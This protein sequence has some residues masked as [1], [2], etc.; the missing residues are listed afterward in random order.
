MRLKRLE[1]YG[2]KSF[3]ERTRMEFGEGITGVVGPNGSGKSNIADA[4]RWVLGEQSAKSLRGA[5]MEDVIFGGTQARKALNFCEVTLVFDNEDGALPIDF[6]EVQVTRRV[7]RSGDSEY[8]LNKSAC[9]LKDIVDLFRD[10]GIGREGYSIVGQGRIDE[11]LSVRSEDRRNVFE[12]AAGIT[13]FKARRQEA[14]RRMENTDQNL[15]RVEDILQE[16]GQKL[17]ALEEQSRAA[18]LYTR[19]MA[20]TRVLEANAFVR[21]SDALDRNI[22]KLD[23]QSADCAAALEELQAQR[24]STQE[25]S[26]GAESRAAE[27]DGALSSLNQELVELTRRSE[28]LRGEG[29]L[30]SQRIGSAGTELE[31]LSAE[32]ESARTQKGGLSAQQAEKRRDM[33][34]R[35]RE[36]DELQARMAQTEAE[37]RAR[38]EDVRAM[39]TRAEE[40]KGEMIASFNRLTDVKAVS[41]RL[42]ATRESLQAQGQKLNETLEKTREGVINAENDLKEAENARAAVQRAQAALKQESQR[43]AESA[44]QAAARMERESAGGQRIAGA[45]REASSRL[46][47]LEQM[48][49]DYDGYQNSVR[50]LLRRFAGDEGLC[51]VAA[52]LLTVPKELER[53]VEMALGPAMQNIVCRR[54]E[55][56]KRMIETLRREHLGRAT[57]LPVSAVRGRTLN[58]R[59]REVLSMPGCLGVASELVQFPEEFRGVFENLLGRTVLAEDLDSGI[60]IMR[61]GNHAFRLVTLE[62]D[63]MHSGGSMTGGSQQAR[64]TSLLSR[65]REIQEHRQA[66]ARLEERLRQSQEEL[67]RLR[68]ESEADRAAQEEIAGRL[69]EQ[70]MEMLRVQTRLAAAKD[71]RAAAQEAV[72]SLEG[73]KERLDD[74][75]KNID[76]EFRQL[77]EQTGEAEQAS[78]TTQADIAAL[79]ERLREGRE[80]LEAV[81]QALAGQSAAHAETKAR[82]EALRREAERLEGDEEQI[83]RSAEVRARARQALEARRAEDERALEQNRADQGEAEGL[84]QEKDRELT[85]VTNERARAQAEL[86]ALTQRIEELSGEL[87]KQRDLSRS[88]ETR[89]NR[90]R[91]EKR[92]LADR[93]WER[94]EL[95]YGSAKELWQEDFDEKSAAARV[96]EIRSQVRA[97]GTVN[98][99]AIQEYEETKERFDAL[100]GQKEDLLKARRDLET[101]VRDLT[102]E[103]ETL[104][105]ERFRQIDQHFSGIFAQLFGG[106]T[107]MLKLQDEADCLNCGIDIV[108]QPPGKKLQLLSLLS[109]GE[110]ALTAIALLFSMLAIRPS[111]FCILDEIEAALD[112]NNVDGFAE[113][114]RNYSQ[115]TQFIV[116]T[117]RKGTM[118]RCDS[119]YGVAMEERGVSRMVSVRLEDVA[120]EAEREEVSP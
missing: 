103:M 63:V 77:R 102:R 18:R 91:D 111:P 69:R 47:M 51:G 6:A 88:L 74:S 10:T 40:A 20:E 48:R 53:A 94:H 119:L 117:H 57:F 49:R 79:N 93:L 67:E 90:A 83:R 45:L 2:F 118:E 58:P 64:T 39:E 23:G 46:K 52:S 89:L 113:Y 17:P 85:R 13:K 42:T 19:L 55:D 71:A 8:L 110:R 56:A 87:E 38:E 61:R 95:T 11:I 21:R 84:L 82:L 98:L 66:V 86:R 108:A 80:A 106:G 100:S 70:E 62:G 28:M 3:A 75:L 76:E 33:E 14:E 15:G 105:R 97:L 78:T 81:R 25:K 24:T 101:I 7:Y 32:E 114:L 104:F 12:E 54:E 72:Y 96:E 41:A 99:A 68:R 65:E 120:A 59:E 5:R 36:L 34:S 60:A 115:N 31:R 37:A 73:E 109:G 92:Q 29:E 4:V 9:R 35:Q 27:L 43:A 30:L 16:V 44:A 26:A 1:I 22:E 116:I 107:A 112:E 50:E